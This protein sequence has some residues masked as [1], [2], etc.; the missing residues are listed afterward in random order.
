MTTADDAKLYRSLLR[1]LNRHRSF[2]VNTDPFCRHAQMIGYYL[3]RKRGYPMLQ[4]E[5]MHCAI[6]IL[7]TV[8]SLYKARNELARLK[9]RRR[10]G[11][12]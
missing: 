9:A 12:P 7:A 8:L 11:T 3:P 4:E 10:A 6:S 1:R 2:P 5:P